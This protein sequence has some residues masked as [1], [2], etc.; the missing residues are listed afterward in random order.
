MKTKF[1]FFRASSGIKTKDPISRNDSMESVR[2]ASLLTLRA[3]I[4]NPRY[5]CYQ[6]TPLSTLI[7]QQKLTEG[8]AL[9]KFIIALHSYH[10]PKWHILLTAPDPQESL[11][12][13]GHS[14]LPFTPDLSLLT[15]F[16]PRTYV[17]NLLLQGFLQRGVKEDGL[18]LMSVCLS[19]FYTTYTRIHAIR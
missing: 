18:G 16:L 10:Q 8:W 3:C 6:T 2:V 11:K 15:S 9:Y 19:P 17:P 13:P 7:Q 5:Q 12:K 1:L 4:S 14:H